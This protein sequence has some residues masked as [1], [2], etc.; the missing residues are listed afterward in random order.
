[1]HGELSTLDK[2][3]MKSRGEQ[4]ASCFPN[5]TKDGK[6]D[7][8]RKEKGLSRFLRHFCVDGTDL[9]NPAGMPAELG[10]IAVQADERG[11][12]EVGLTQAGLEFVMLENAIFD[13]EPYGDALSG[14]PRNPH[15]SHHVNL[16]KVA[17]PMAVLPEQ[18]YGESPSSR[19]SFTPSPTASSVR[20]PWTTPP[21]LSADGSDF[22]AIAWE[23]YQYTHSAVMKSQ[24]VAVLVS[25]PVS[26]RPLQRLTLRVSICRAGIA[27]ISR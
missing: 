13:A 11:Q 9:A 24:D 22:P 3:F 2:K 10:F 26:F 19:R 8:E 7:K 12:P 25:P 17:G 15:R 16:W 14:G 6:E 4:L 18:C 1:M 23:M 20:A 5:P 21:H 27:P